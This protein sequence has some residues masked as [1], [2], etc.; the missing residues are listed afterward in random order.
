M[1]PPDVQRRFTDPVMAARDDA[2]TQCA[3]GVLLVRPARFGYNSQTAETNRF[4]SS[5]PQASVAAERARIEFDAL[6]AAIEDAG[7]G[8]CALDDSSE[9]AKPDAVF[10]N[11]WVS[12]HRDG[13]IVLYPMQAPNRRAERRVEV[14]EGVEAR[15]G[16][17]RSRLLDLRHHENEGRILEGTGSLVLDH[18]QRI[19]YACRSAR[20][21]ESLVREWAALMS[22]EPLLLDARGSDGMPVYHTN[23]LLSI[24]SRWAVVC[25]EAIVEVDRERVL[26]RLHDSGRD[27]IE[28][29]MRAMARFAGNILELSGSEAGAG[30]HSVLVLS[31][32][33]R[34]ALQEPDSLDWDRL[35]GCVDAVVAAAVPIIESVG[36]GSV[37]CM[38]AEVPDT[39]A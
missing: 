12:F 8:L 3:E 2:G 9:P 32:Q 16:F 15:L 7:V 23:V 28:I 10:P 25:T 1:R 11:N 31:Q 37:R 4:Q 26:Q 34:A 35:S 6:A 20:T 21:D 22:Y 5:A 38:L 18:V 39:G 24:G 29:S 36:G 33:A 14:V 17:K 30:M 13:T 19:A 27:I